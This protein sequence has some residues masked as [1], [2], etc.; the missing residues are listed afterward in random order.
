MVL[1]GLSGYPFSC[2]DMIGGGEWTSFL[3]E[4]ILDQDLI[5]RSAQLHAL[6]PMMQFSV[7]PWRV[8]DSVHLN[9]A[10]AA[11]SLRSKFTPYIMQLAHI[12]AT[13]GEPILKSMEYEFPGQGFETVIDQ[14]MLG[15]KLLVAPMLEKGKEYRNVKFP[16]GKWKASDGNILKGGKT[17]QQNV[18]LDQ[19][20]YFEKIN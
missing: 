2:P 18:A 12:A 5:V 19:L 6:M 3:D 10:K 8:L 15:D 20:L 14:F 17:Y 13:T 4:S 9:A 11:V 1:E 7:A 16:N